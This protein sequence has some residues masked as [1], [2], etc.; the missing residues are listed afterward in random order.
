LEQTF[1]AKRDPEVRI[2]DAQ[3]ASL[4]QMRRSLS[5]M[6]GRLTVAL[7]QADEIKQQ[8]TGAKVSMARVTV[9]AAVTTE[10]SG[11]EREVDGVIRVLRGQGGFG[12]GGGGGAGGVVAPSTVAQLVA[13]AGGINRATAMPTEYEQ[14]A[15]DAIPAKLDA[16]I[17]KLNAALARMPAF[18]KSLDDAG[19]PWSPGRPVRDG[20]H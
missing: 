16:E 4:T 2:S 19:V 5:E 9:P 6:Q 17:A 14:Q 7:K 20:Q 15:L 8:I 10:A 13:Q 11:I 1:T 3:I 18:L 12:F